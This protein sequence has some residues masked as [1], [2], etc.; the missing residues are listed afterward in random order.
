[1]IIV[2]AFCL[3]VAHPGPIFGTSTANL[4]GES[5]EKGSFQPKTIRD[6]EPV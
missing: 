4:D 2:A 6:E 1:M 5:G 3:N